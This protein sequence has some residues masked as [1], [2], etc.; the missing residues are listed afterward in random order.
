MNMVSLK[1]DCYGLLIK[2]NE[3]DCVQAKNILIY[4]DPNRNR[5]ILPRLSNCKMDCSCLA[6]SLFNS[7]Q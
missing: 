2:E 4:I 5:I 7:G 3:L 6:E 1:S